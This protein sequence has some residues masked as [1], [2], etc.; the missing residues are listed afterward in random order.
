MEDINTINERNVTLSPSSQE[1]ESEGS[2]VY[3]ILIA[4]I[5]IIILILLVHFIRYLY[6][7]YNASGKMVRIRFVQDRQHDSSSGGRGLLNSNGIVQAP[8]IL[9]RKD[10]VFF[11]FF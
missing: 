11:N 5:S 7:R 6:R 8:L 2:K 10:F 9:N 3:Y 4:L 1:S